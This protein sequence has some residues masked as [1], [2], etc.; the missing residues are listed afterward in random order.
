MVKE[1][2]K[3]HLAR[4]YNNWRIFAWKFGAKK[5][6]KIIRR[7]KLV[8]F[9]QKWREITCEN[10]QARSIH[11]LSG[12]RRRCKTARTALYT[13]HARASA[14]HADRKLL[15]LTKAR[16]NVRTSRKSLFIWYNYAA[17][18]RA[19]RLMLLR[20]DSVLCARVYACWCDKVELRCS[21]REAVMMGQARAQACGLSW[22]MCIWRRVA[23][24]LFG[25]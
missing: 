24:E 4:I 10:L 5:A 22:A 8:R 17:K 9:L 12:L 25:V 21:Q 18:G 7:S 11:E 14:V 1:R 2:R 20:K 3:A 6:R 19:C 16:L 23:G 13:W 15:V